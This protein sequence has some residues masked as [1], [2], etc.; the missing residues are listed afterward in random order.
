[1]FRFPFRTVAQA[2]TSDISKTAY[3]NEKIR[4]IISNLCECSST[5]LIFSQHVKKVEV[6]ELDECNHPD[7]MRLILSVNK[8]DVTT[9]GESGMKSAEPFIRECSK[10]WKQYCESNMIWYQSRLT[11]YPFRC[12]V[13]TITT[14][15]ESSELNHCKPANRCDQKWLVVSA[16]GSDSSLAIAHSPEGRDRGYL[17]CGGAAFLFQK[18]LN[19]SSRDLR[20]ELFCF[21]P[22]SIPTGLPVHVNGSFAIMSNR[23]GIWKRTVMQ[24][25]QIEVDW[26]EALM[27][28]ALARAYIM[29]LEN[30]KDLINLVP[31]YEFHTLWPSIFR[32]DMHSWK[33]LVEKVCT[34]LLDTQS[35]LFYSDGLWMSITDGIL[36]SA[37]FNQIY[38][39]SVEILRSLG[40]HVFNLPSNIFL[41]LKEFDCR[42]ILQRRTLNFTEFLKQHFFPNIQHFASAWRDEI[43]CFGLDCILVTG[44]MNGDGDLF[45]RNACIAVSANSRFLVKP[46]DLIHP[47]GAAAKLFS[48]DDHRFPVGNGL[49]DRNR[50]CALE[51]LGM[52]QDLDWKGILERAQ[53][54]SRR[55]VLESSRKLIKYLNDRI[56]QLGK[57]TSHANKL[58]E[59]LNILPVL[60]KPAVEYILPWKGSTNYS[61]RLCAPRNVF[62]PK[63]ANLVGSSCLIVDTS[64]STGCGKL[65]N[66]VEDLLGFSKRLPEDKFV[67]QQLDEAM[68][69][70]NKLSQYKKQEKRFAIQS[71]C[72]KIYEFFNNR[73][74][75][76]AA[77]TILEKLK[78][79]QWLF[80]EGRFVQTK[81][82]AHTLNAKGAPFLFVLPLNYQRNYSDLFQAIH[83]K[84]SFDEKDFIDAL[85]DLNRAKQGSPLTKDELQIATFFITEIYA[86]NMALEENIDDIYRIPSI[87]YLLPDTNGI[88]RPSSSLVVNFN[89]W[90]DDPDDNL[91]VHENI[92]PQTA[93][94]LGAKS[95]KSVILKSRANYI[96]YGESFGQHEELTDRLKGILDGYPVDG[97]LK[98]LVQNADDAQASE[99]HLIHDTRSLKS[100]KVATNKNSDEILGP[101][102]CVFNDRPFSKE[103][104]D[105]IRNLGTG[106]KKDKPKMAGKYGIGFNSVYTLQTARVFY[107]MIILWRFLILT[108]AI[109]KIMI[110][111]DCL[112]LSRMRNLEV[113]SQIR[114][115]D[116][117]LNT[118]NYV[119]RQCFVFL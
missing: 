63:D 27:E 24:N 26:N 39:T 90:L 3:G 8:P 98:E 84:D 62:L 7:E 55:N 28:D 4:A 25:Q 69:Y 73:V 112:S 51:I 83:I 43:V 66:K 19:Q 47:R 58:L 92:P 103:D 2:Q 60:R 64:D 46:A 82:V 109:L 17:P 49:R 65:N 53:V 99:I 114:L 14:T 76:E 89:L 13:A 81:K 79:Q 61:Q 29:L 10:W 97:I 117:F 37:D 20:G 91:K 48:E 100:E 75:K 70:W 95:L 106:S 86:T 6:Y 11:E 45:R 56:S 87:G 38:E 108:A 116:I 42:K 1:M 15:I 107:Q 16:S 50:L 105:G 115:R 77:A 59:E 80:I 23:V 40:I 110:V 21:F 52:V 111:A 9:L 119:V 68:K 41:T 93:Y 71:V 101:A 36:L 31:H 57:P 33:R 30:M 32:V 74:V 54:L 34:V 102:L 35:E 96:G 18:A 104:L 88:L 67:L 5:L 94:H 22:L 72:E 118:L 85:S 44:G 12:E 78:E 113:T